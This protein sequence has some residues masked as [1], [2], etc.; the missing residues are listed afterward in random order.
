MAHHLNTTTTTQRRQ[1]APRL[2]A[3]QTRDAWDYLTELAG[4]ELP[5]RMSGRDVA[6]AIRG[7][8]H[9]AGGWH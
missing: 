6:A 5:N 3:C 9:G 1:R 4:D 2:T 8:G 7:D